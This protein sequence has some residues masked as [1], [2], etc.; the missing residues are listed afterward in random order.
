MNK[1]LA[2][3]VSKDGKLRYDMEGV[4]VV[5]GLE[6][7]MDEKPMVMVRGFHGSVLPLDALAVASGTTFSR[8]ELS[9][10]MDIA[11]TKIAAQRR[12]H[13][14][15]IDAERI[16]HEFAL[17]CA[18]QTLD[19][20][21][22]NGI[23]VDTRSHEALRIKR[24]WLDGRATDEEL[25]AAQAAAWDARAAAGAAAWDAARDAADA[26]WDAAR[27]AARA[28]ARAVARGSMWDAQNEK[29]ETMLLEAIKVE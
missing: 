18:T 26:A 24:L 3:H 14:Y 8:V 2:W 22:H 19:A 27:D 11:T 21:V 15:V 28:V 17:W 7:A 16:L 9:G 12:K 25:I 4:Q 29:L 13:L 10:E 6:L 20:C 1:I 5:A 23:E